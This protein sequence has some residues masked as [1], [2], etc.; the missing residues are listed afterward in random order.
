MILPRKYNFGRVSACID[1]ETRRLATPRAEKTL[2]ESE[3]DHD[4]AGIQRKEKKKQQVRNIQDNG[5]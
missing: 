2:A 3:M 1:R 4:A 5:R